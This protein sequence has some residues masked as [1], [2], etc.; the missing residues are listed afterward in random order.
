MCNNKRKHEGIQHTRCCLIHNIITPNFIRQTFM[1]ELRQDL[2]HVKPLS[3]QSAV[4]CLELYKYNRRVCITVAWYS[5]VV[6]AFAYYNREVG[7]SNSVR[8]ITN[9][10]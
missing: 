8:V 4:L 5:S 10:L 2:C 7:G 9:R 3:R 1:N 6:R